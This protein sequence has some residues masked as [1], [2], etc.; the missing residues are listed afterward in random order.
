MTQEFYRTLGVYTTCGCQIKKTGLTMASQYFL[1]TCPSR[2]IF[3]RE[4]ILLLVPYSFVVEVLSRQLIVKEGKW[5]QKHATLDFDRLDFIIIRGQGS[6]NLQLRVSYFTEDGGKSGFLTPASVLP[7]Y[8]PQ[9][10]ATP[11]TRSWTALVGILFL[12][13]FRKAGLKVLYALVPFS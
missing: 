13:S 1:R 6:S 11:R 3:A 2:K 10:S 12:E 8:L 9:R 4:S 7:Q 5:I